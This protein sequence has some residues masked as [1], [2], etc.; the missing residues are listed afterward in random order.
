MVADYVWIPHD[1]LAWVPARVMS[2]S[3]TN[4]SVQEI[5][6]GEERWIDNDKLG[7]VIEDINAAKTLISDMVQLK[8]VCCSLLGRIL[9]HV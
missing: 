3:Y 9:L 8:E 6:S 1:D 7:P 4:I 5:E 2:R